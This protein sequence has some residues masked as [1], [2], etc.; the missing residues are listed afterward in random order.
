MNC[1]EVAELL[2][3]YAL[4]ALPPEEKQAVEGHL[5]TCNLHAEMVSLFSAAATVSFTTATEAPRPEL[6]SRILDAIARD[7]PEATRHPVRE[8]PAP[9]AIPLT[10]IRD[11]RLSL[12]PYA[13]AAVFAL[14]SIGLLAWNV[15][16]LSDGSSDSGDTRVVLFAGSPG[17]GAVIVEDDATVVQVA[18][19]PA[20]EATQ[21]YQLWVIEDGPPQPAGLLATDA[22]GNASHNLG[23]TVAATA[24]IA[25][26]VEPAGGSAQP[27]SDPILVAEL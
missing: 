8:L 7:D 13:L 20:L 1:A 9:V 15:F 21:V 3:A 23:R 4:D 16:L 24:V 25:I 11:R 27:T 19:L 18:G 6:R 14:V 12:A 22:G 10:P 26:T 17:S 2:G 5:A